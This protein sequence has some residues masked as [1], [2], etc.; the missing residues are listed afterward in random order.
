M[1]DGRRPHQWFAPDLTW[2]PTATTASKCLFA[3][4]KQTNDR[5]HLRP[6]PQ[7]KADERCVYLLDLVPHE[8]GHPPRGRQSCSRATRRARTRC[9]LYIFRSSSPSLTSP[10]P[11]PLQTSPPSWVLGLRPAASHSRRAEAPRQAP[12]YSLLTGDN[13]RSGMRSFCD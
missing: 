12:A 13:P 7:R 2:S 10:A 9:L 5:S 4:R 6:P 3:S 11:C 8:G 1:P